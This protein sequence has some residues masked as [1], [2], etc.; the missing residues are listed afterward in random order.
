MHKPDLT[1]ARE[2]LRRGR[3]HI[4]DLETRI[5]AFLATDFY[6][7][8]FEAD[9]REGRMKVLFDS[10]HEPDKRVN[11]VIGDAVGNLR[12]AL[13]YL[14]V[15]LAAPLAGSTEGLGFPFANDDKGFSGEVRSKRTLG[16]AE[17]AIQ[18]YFIQEVQAYNGG[19]GH[20]LWVL[21]KL[22]N[23]DKHRLLV[24]TASMA[25]VRASWVDR[26]GNVFT[27]CEFGVLAGQNGTF[28]N[29]P[30]NSIKFTE[31]PKPMFEIQFREP[32]YVDGQVVPVFLHGAAGDV[33][34]LLDAIEVRLN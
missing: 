24:A 20:A 14:V 23:I 10:L 25:G 3:D 11:A 30:I 8:R 18:D 22:R 32:P 2:K 34:R 26:G 21:N 31:Q 29:A 15:A 4:A 19:K 9:Q 13:D 33:E 1:D 7:L 27:D 12:S 5:G 17:A 6:R 28:I 16:F